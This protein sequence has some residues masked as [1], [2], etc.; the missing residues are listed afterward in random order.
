LAFPVPAQERGVPA[1]AVVLLGVLLVV[2]AYAGWYRLSSDGTLPAET[3]AQVPLHLAPLAEQAAR[4]NVAPRVAAVAT[5]AASADPTTMPQPEAPPAASISPG[6]A[7]AAA[8]TPPP[9]PP[10]VSDQPRIVLRATADAW[11]QVRDRAGQILLNRTLHPGET[12]AVP[13]RPNL[14]LTTGNAGGTDLVVD[15]LTSL[16]L[17]GNGVVRRDVPL[18]PDL[19][20]DGKVT[21]A[22]VQQTGARPTT[23]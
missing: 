12:W 16:S 11:M 2:G 17:G 20:K 5:V 8:V 4:F 10:D 13:A 9:V 22:G 1:G 18:E 23:Q 15:G 7:A 3:N 21:A 14:L 6:S 19:I